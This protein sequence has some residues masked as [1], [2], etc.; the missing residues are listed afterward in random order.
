MEGIGLGRGK[1]KK[2]F[3]PFG[4][5]RMLQANN[6]RSSFWNFMVENNSPHLDGLK[7]WIFQPGM[8]F[9]SWEQWWGEPK[10]RIAAHEGLDLFSFEDSNGIQK[11]V[12]KDTKIP[13]TFAGE[14]VKIDNDFL[15]K[16]IYL[17]HEIADEGGR[18]L[19]TVYGHTNPRASLRAGTKVA[20]G[21]I[22]GCISAAIHKKT[23]ILPHLHLTLAWVPAVMP[24]DQL[25][26]QNLSND[27]MITLIDPLT[28]L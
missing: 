24:P 11:T 3:L 19:Y 4:I 5:G 7:K 18:R 1:K 9:H 14:V 26:W 2:E 12:D 23:T 6:L 25:T 13:A 28:V 15:G 10:R 27:P 17:R 16:S 8:L 22:I 20:E 21:E